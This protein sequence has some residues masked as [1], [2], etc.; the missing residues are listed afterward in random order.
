MMCSK[1]I[2]HAAIE[3]VLV[4]ERGYLGENGVDYLRENGVEVQAV[5][6]P[7]DPRFSEE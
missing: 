6:G 5:P 1:M 7:E 4:V 2:H 3:R